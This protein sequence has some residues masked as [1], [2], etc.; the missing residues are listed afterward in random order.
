MI[1]EGK[2]ESGVLPAFLFP[3]G[4]RRMREDSHVAAGNPE[5]RQGPPRAMELA[6]KVPSI[7]VQPLRSCPSPS[8]LHWERLSPAPGNPTSC[9]KVN[10]QLL[11]T[12]IAT[13]KISCCLINFLMKTAVQVSVQL[14]KWRHA[15]PSPSFPTRGPALLFIFIPFAGLLTCGPVVLY[16]KTFK[17]KVKAG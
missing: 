14:E 1:P 8:A 12:V 13:V 11:E 17:I 10:I 16:R 7:Q 5:G 9:S 6:P 15:C 4:E 2:V 3:R